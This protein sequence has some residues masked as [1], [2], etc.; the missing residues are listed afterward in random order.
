MHK[1]CLTKCLAK[2]KSNYSLKILWV[3]FIKLFNHLI[4]FTSLHRPYCFTLPSSQCQW[5]C[6]QKYPKTCSFFSIFLCRD[7]SLTKTFDSCFFLLKKYL[8]VVSLSHI[9]SSLNHSIKSAIG[10]LASQK[11]AIAFVGNFVA[12]PH[13]VT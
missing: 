6:G 5:I 4:A 8:I 3:N 9:T 10:E 13:Q 1:S 11:Q 12:T 2:I 7:S